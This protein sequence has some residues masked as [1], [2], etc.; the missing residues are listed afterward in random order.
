MESVLLVTL[1]IVA[2]IEYI[3]INKIVKSYRQVSKYSQY[4]EEI[5]KFKD[6]AD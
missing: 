5:I 4:L 1:L 3:V 6:N 2:I